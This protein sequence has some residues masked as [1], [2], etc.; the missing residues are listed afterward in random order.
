[1]TARLA[2]FLIVLAA[3]LALEQVAATRADILAHKAARAWPSLA[4]LAS[5]ALCARLILPVGLVGVALGA[6]E[7]GVGLFNVLDAP[8][9]LAVVTSWILL[10]LA[11]WCQHVAMH[12]AGW[13][14]RLHR[15]HHSDTT[16]DVWTAFR[17][18]PLEIVISLGWKAAVVILLGA[19][20]EAVL[21]F[22]IALS[23]AAMLNHANLSLPPKL[24]RMLAQVLATPTFHLVHHHPDARLTD[25]N[26]GNVLSVWDHW[27]GLSRPAA[28]GPVRIGIDGV[29]GDD[30]LLALLVQ[31]FR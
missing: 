10:D 12:K 13:L 15:V 26:F 6:Q 9:W 19:P 23:T 4:L 28:D 31:P 2:P 20:V 11:I 1:M 27:T 17:F 3:V 8:G 16:M 24:D 30:R 25:S 14:W 29:S 21:I 22:E 18:H 7:I 5:G